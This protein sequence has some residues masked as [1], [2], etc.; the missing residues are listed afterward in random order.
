M[1]LRPAAR[2]DLPTTIDVLLKVT[3]PLPEIT[4]NRPPLN[5]G[6]VLDRSGSMGEAR[7]I[8]F[9]REAVAFAVRE[10][11]AT[12]RVSVTIFDD[13]IET[14]VPNGPA[15]D[16][17]A[18][19][20]L[21]EAIQPRNTTALHGGWQEGGRQVQTNR[22]SE[23]VNRVILLSDGLANVGES[24]PDKIADDVHK[25]A[26]AGVSTTTLGLGDQ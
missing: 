3:P 25:L 24:R 10:L 13:Q 2:S 11:A 26:E 22:Q 14:I 12:D 8:T 21:I 16:K 1:P 17:D 18:I 15:A 20:R 6:F 23:G 19:C 7:K 9:A 5:L 4:G